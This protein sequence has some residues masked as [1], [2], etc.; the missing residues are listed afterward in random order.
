[1][2][3]T[4]DFGAGTL[5]A[6]LGALLC[7]TGCPDGDDGETS[8][9]DDGSGT[10]DTGDDDCAEACEDGFTCVD[11]T[12]CAP[13]Q[14]CADVCCD[15]D[16]VCSFQQCVVPGET[17]ID[18]AGKVVWSEEPSAKRGLHRVNWNLRE[19]VEGDMV[20]RVELSDRVEG[21]DHHHVET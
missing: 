7:L 1:M 21:V 3:R 15:G 5:Y 16:T 2:G 20:A 13:E 14:T 6:A 4:H 11:G 12:C 17:C 8:L 19:R 18:A 10:A 9:D